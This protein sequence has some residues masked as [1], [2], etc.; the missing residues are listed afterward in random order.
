MRVRCLGVAASILSALAAAS[1]VTADNVEHPECALILHEERAELEQ[2][3]LAVKLAESRLAAAESIFALVDELWKDELIEQFLHLTAKH[4]RDVAVID[5]KRR[6][7]LLK[8][9]DAL[10]EQFEIICSPPADKQAESDRVARREEARRRYLQADC[11]SI[12]KDLAIA[13]VDLAYHT[14]VL[15]SVNDLR[16]NGVA[17]RQDVI[18]AEEDVELALQRIRHHAPRVQA[19]IAPQS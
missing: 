11:H 12:G 14:E 6:K 2:W 9:Q 8:R 17:T 16:E 3:E 7:L 1:A 10:I 15:A 5:V 18:R 13:E 19:C 4:E